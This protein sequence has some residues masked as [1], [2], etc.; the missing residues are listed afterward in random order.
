MKI[1]FQLHHIFNSSKARYHLCIDERNRPMSVTV[2]RV[3]VVRAH[4][5]LKGKTILSGCKMARAM[6]SQSLDKLSRHPLRCT[7]SFSIGLSA[8]PLCIDRLAVFTQQTQTGVWTFISF[9]TLPVVLP[10]DRVNYGMIRMVDA[11]I[12]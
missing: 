7:C 11:T 8:Y 5:N 2:V 6:N 4:A 9:C 1:F 10:D 3:S 12:S